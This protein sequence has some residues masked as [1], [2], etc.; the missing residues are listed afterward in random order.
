MASFMEAITEEINR[1]ASIDYSN[2]KETKIPT[3]A[4]DNRSIDLVLDSYPQL[5]SEAYRAWHANQ[6][7]RLGVKTYIELAERAIK[8]GRN[9]QKLMSKLLSER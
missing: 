3:I 8:Y 1:R 4:I 2:R 6:M 7:K 9:P 5:V